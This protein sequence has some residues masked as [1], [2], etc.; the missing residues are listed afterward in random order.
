MSDARRGA[1]EGR[2]E[3]DVYEISRYV[4]IPLEIAMSSIDDC[5]AWKIFSALLAKKKSNR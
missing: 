4:N 5:S 2:C 1:A 3:G